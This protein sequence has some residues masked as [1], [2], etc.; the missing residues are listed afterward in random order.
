MSGAEA[1]V[2][3]HLPLL[4]Q[5]CDCS[6]LPGYSRGVGNGKGVRTGYAPDQSIPTLLWDHGDAIRAFPIGPIEARWL[7]MR[8]HFG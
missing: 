2:Y 3:V 8:R 5:V 7:Q 4:C 6:C 1:G